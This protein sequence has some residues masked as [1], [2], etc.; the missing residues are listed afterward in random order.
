MNTTEQILPAI[1]NSIS[2]H[3]AILDESGKILDVNPAWEAY[4]KTNG[5]F[6]E[7]TGKG[8][9][10]LDTCDASSRQGNADAP[11]VATG[12]RNLFNSDGMQE[13]SLEYPC[14]SSDEQSWYKLKAWRLDMEADK[15]AVITHKEVTQAVLQ[16]KAL[17][18]DALTDSLTGIANRRHFD[19]FLAQEWRRD[20]RR[21]TPITLI[22]IDIDYF[23]LLNDNYGHL[24]GDKC[25][26]RIAQFISSIAQRPG[27]L[28]AR[29]GGE[30][31]A[32]VMGATQ[33]NAAK[34]F[35]EFIRAGIEQLDIP[36]EHSTVSNMITAS[37][38][39]STTVPLRAANKTELVAMA[40]EALY[41]AKNK[42]RNTVVIKN[43]K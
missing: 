27:D 40:D 21:G 8:S 15:Y 25:L 43:S 31:F 42:G 9:N 37:V 23:K 34:Q 38:G 14:H 19:R 20:M 39:V 22:M 32:L 2:K 24:T 41:S 12:I 28:A 4:A 7:H 35:A 11:I 18:A 33:E 13:F 36:N 16:R 5:G 1:W 26:K 17:Q 6:S 30:E 3:V 29:I 10:Y